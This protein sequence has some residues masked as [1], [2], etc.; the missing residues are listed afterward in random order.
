MN[1]EIACF[2]ILVIFQLALMIQRIIPK[3]EMLVKYIIKILGEIMFTIPGC[4]WFHTITLP[5][6]TRLF[7]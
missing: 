4:V 1:P 3:K 6:V 7:L 2:G 5:W